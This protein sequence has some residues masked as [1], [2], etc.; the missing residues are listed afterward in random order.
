MKAAIDLQIKGKTQHVTLID[1][2]LIQAR[3]NALISTVFDIKEE[4]S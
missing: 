3:L 1:F 4:I 2:L